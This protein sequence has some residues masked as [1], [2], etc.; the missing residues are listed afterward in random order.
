MHTSAGLHDEGSLIDSKNRVT[1]PQL[2]AER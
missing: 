2:R 1:R